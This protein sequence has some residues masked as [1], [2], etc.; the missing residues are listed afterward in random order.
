MAIESVATVMKEPQF[1]NEPNIF[2]S[3]YAKNATKETFF[4]L[5]DIVS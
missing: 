1:S 4:A 5:I 2:P 3:L